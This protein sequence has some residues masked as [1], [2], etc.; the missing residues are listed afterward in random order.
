MKLVWTVI[1]MLPIVL[2]G[3]VSSALVYWYE[4]VPET[5]P[6]TIYIQADKGL[7]GC[8]IGF[9]HV[10]TPQNCAA[11]G[12][13]STADRGLGLPDSSPT[14]NC[15]DL[16]DLDPKWDYPPGCFVEDW[17]GIDALCW[18][19]NTGIDS[20][21]SPSTN[22]LANS[23]VSKVCMKHCPSNTYVYNNECVCNVGYQDDG[24]GCQ[25]LLQAHDCRDDQILSTL[26]NA[27]V[28]PMNLYDDGSTCVSR[29]FKTLQTGLCNSE[30]GWRAPADEFECAAGVFVA[31]ADWLMATDPS[32]VDGSHTKDNEWPNFVKNGVPTEEWNPGVTG[33]Y[34]NSANQPWFNTAVT[35]NTCDHAHLSNSHRWKC[36]CVRDACPDDTYEYEQTCVTSCPCGTHLSVDQKSCDRVPCNPDNDFGCYQD[37]DD[38]FKKACGKTITNLIL[39]A[40]SVFN[41]EVYDSNV[42][43][44]SGVGCA[45]PAVWGNYSH[46]NVVETAFVYEHLADGLE[47]ENHGDYNRIVM[48]V[49]SETD[50]DTIRTEYGQHLN[51]RMKQFKKMARSQK[52]KQR[53]II[54]QEYSGKPMR[55]KRERVKASKLSLLK[56]DLPEVYATIKNRM[57]AN[58]AYVEAEYDLQEVMDC[59]SKEDD[60][61]NCCSYDFSQDTDTTVMVGLEET[62]GA[63]S[64]LCDGSTIVSKQTRKSLTNEVLGSANYDMQCWNGVQF[65][66]SVTIAT[67]GEH[68][69][70]SY[71]VL[72]GSQFIDANP[73]CSSHSCSSGSLKS[74]PDS[75]TCSSPT[76][77]DSECCDAPPPS[78]VPD[79]SGD[80][81]VCIHPDVTVR[82]LVGVEAKAVA[83]GRLNVGDLVI[84]EGRTSTVKRIERFQVND[85]ACVVPRDLCGGFSDPVLVSQT[86]AVR[87]PSW[88]ANTWTFCQPDWQRVATTEYVHV[89][90]ESY[91]DDHL[92]SG[93]VV[94]ESWDGYARATDAISDACDKQGCPWPHKWVPSGDQ[95]WTRVDL[96]Q[97]LFDSSPR[98]RIDRV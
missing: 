61:P 16:I 79:D 29:V 20:D 24:A 11:F 44:D 65:G 10:N 80:N 70:G 82:V 17:R 55:Q 95:R 37:S 23:I 98:L 3:H 2:I 46:G 72:V 68:A 83:V 49:S 1:Q 67:G 15:R 31:G 35:G 14:T 39:S 28:C 41:G 32:P 43:F 7:S 57:K 48:A 34:L 91:L 47:I 60:I 51:V 71:I 81:V 6:P 40:D 54:E 22:N 75:I 36:I 88:P 13:F 45:G 33:C 62:V 9:D 64:V 4:P 58:I 30:P 74:S 59:T 19:E 90:L 85:D 8:P 87:C 93:S 96:R 25:P 53:A 50:P 77:T 92:L 21:H 42:K 86:H 84:G 56:N 26:E 76:C 63:W 97:I 27:C 73:T 89:E 18:N 69:C 5:Q 38:V 66:N 94:L 52:T 78:E 12:P